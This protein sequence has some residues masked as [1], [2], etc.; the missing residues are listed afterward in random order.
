MSFKVGDVVKLKSSGPDMTID[1]VGETVFP[2]GSKVS[3]VLCTWFVG[4]KLEK[5]SFNPETLTLSS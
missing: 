1:F 5:A 4:K 2:H 3:V